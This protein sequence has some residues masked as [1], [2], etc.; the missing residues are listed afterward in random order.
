MKIA[1]IFT[2][3]DFGGVESQACIISKNSTT[4]A[5]HSFVAITH[6]G[7]AAELI[8]KAGGDVT[9]L[10]TKAS[11]PSL[12][13]IFLLYKYFRTNKPDVVHT[14]GAEANFHGLIAAWLA[15]VPVRIGE[16]IGIPKHGL[17]A[18]LMFKLAYFFSSKVVGISSAVTSWLLESGEVPVHKAIKIYN[19]VVIPS[20]RIKDD[21]STGR[22]RIGFVGRLEPVKN[23]LALVEALA[24]IV[25][26]G[27]DAELSI[28]GDGSQ[29]QLLIDRAAELQISD[30]VIVHGFQDKPD[31]YV[32]RCHVYV[33]PSISEG[34]GLALVE[35]M[36]CAVPVIATAVGG[37][38]EIIDDGYTGWLINKT[39]AATI[40]SKLIEVLAMPEEQL[41]D[42][43]LQGYQSVET[44]FEPAAYMLELESL[45]TRE[46]QKVRR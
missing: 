10:M 44:R 33:Q 35:A 6:G 14:R 5:N 17:K 29:K 12:N 27:V 40:A 39:D 23:P 18:K 3:L 38:P 45:Y 9:I 32:R 34:F 30:R 11:I 25:K 28:V 37:A 13:A 8:V 43:G 26:Q 31:Q 46:L 4:N 21:I 24:L 22:F 7:R 2:S 42:V 1:N 19:P 36:G 20:P 16:E 41:F 15:G